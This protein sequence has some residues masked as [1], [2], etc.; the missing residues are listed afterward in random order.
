MGL[1]K[2]LDLKRLARSAIAMLTATATLALGAVMTGTAMADPAKP[3]IDMRDAAN[4]IAVDMGGYDTWLG[5][6]FVGTHGE[7]GYCTDS[8]LI[9]AG[10]MAYATANWVPSDSSETATRIGYILHEVDYPTSI[11]TLPVQTQRQYTLDWAAAAYVVHDK[12]DHH[13][14]NWVSIKNAMNNNRG[15]TAQ[16]WSGLSEYAGGGHYVGAFT[17]G[18]I[19]DRAAQLWNESAGHTAGV[20]VTPDNSYKEAQRHGTTKDV[21]YRDANGNYVST[22]VTVTL[23]GSANP[24]FDAAANGMYGG[25]VSADGKSWTGT[26]QPNLGA[27]GLQLPFTAGADGDYYTTTTYD[28]VVYRYELANPVNGKQRMARWGTGTG[29]PLVKTGK[30]WKL[31]W[32]FQPQATTVADPKRLE[33]GDTP[34]DKV[35]SSVGDLI[36]GTGADGTITGRIPLTT[37]H[38]ERGH[39]GSGCGY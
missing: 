33:P 16:G 1:G 35:T 30:A 13:P 4:G 23:H 37:Q 8:G 6:F 10:I 12:I 17:N 11:E 20:S 9:D 25:T 39:Q 31:Q 38:V 36:S 18:D 24:K 5:A 28:H 34:V 15:A 7:K 29:D 22:K 27:T 14:E 32:S 19:I 21:A 3:R 26:T 2:S